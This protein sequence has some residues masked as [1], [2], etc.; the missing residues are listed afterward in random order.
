[1]PHLLIAEVSTPFFIQLYSWITRII[2]ANACRMKQLMIDSER[3]AG[4]VSRAIKSFHGKIISMKESDHAECWRGGYLV[5]VPVTRNCI[6][7]RN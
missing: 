7:S 4:T 6:F 2:M 3:K 1:M 5:A